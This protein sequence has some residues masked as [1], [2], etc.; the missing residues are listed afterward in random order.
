VLSA[1]QDLSVVQEQLETLG[2]RELQEQRVLSVTRVLRALTRP[3]LD[4]LEL[5]VTQG[6]LVQLEQ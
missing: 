3:L 4:L 6:L 2:R 5:L 1:T